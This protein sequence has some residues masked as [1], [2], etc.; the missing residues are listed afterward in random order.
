MNVLNIKHIDGILDAG[1]NVVRGQF[2]IVVR[3]NGGKRH[4]FADQ[5]QHVAHRNSRVGQAGLPKW[6]VGSIEIRWCMRNLASD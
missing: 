6:I 4:A 5:F 1:P 3:D 2:W